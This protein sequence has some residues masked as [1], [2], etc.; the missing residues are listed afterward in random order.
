MPSPRPSVSL[1]PIT[2]EEQQNKDAFYAYGAGL[3][4]WLGVEGIEPKDYPDPLIGT[5]LADNGGFFKFDG[6]E[7]TWWQSSEVRDD[8]FYQGTYSVLPG[9][10][11]NAG[12]VLRQGDE[13]CFSVFQHYTFRKADGVDEARNYHGVFIIETKGADTLMVLNQRTMGTFT[14]TRVTA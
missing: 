14:L 13:M 4:L 3:A 5:W 2:P 11:T 12:Y 1:P 8:N 10:K 6:A 7:F 9:A